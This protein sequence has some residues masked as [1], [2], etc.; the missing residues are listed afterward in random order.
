MSRG[1]GESN[2]ADAFTGGDFHSMVLDPNNPGRIFVGGHEAVSVSQDS[3][4]TWRQIPALKDRDAMGWGFDSETVYVSGHPGLTVSHDGGKTFS[5][6]NQGLPSTDVHAFGGGGGVLYGASPQAGFFSSPD[7][8]R[9]WK[10]VN[11]NEGRSFFG[12]ILVDPNNP[13]RLLAADAAAGVAESID[14]G[15]TFA[16]LGGVS[17]PTWL[18]W[19]PNN[20]KLLVASGQQGAA[21]SDDGGRTW[22]SLDLP[23]LPAMVEVDPTDPQR[24][25]AGSHDGSNVSLLVSDDGGVTWRKP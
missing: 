9:S 4:R 22:S 23:T 19:D 8:G 10:V 18:S 24:L 7:G 3:G 12:R 21:R 15:R 1:G 6:R 25:Y 2:A 16:D 20:P 14:G 5:E 17:A 11:P 13:M